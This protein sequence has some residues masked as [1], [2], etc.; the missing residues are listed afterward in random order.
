MGIEEITSRIVS[1]AETEAKSIGD[2]AK[3]KSGAVLAEARARAD[4]MTGDARA[5][6]EED[7][8]KMLSRRQS[9]AEIDG[10]K[11]I[12]DAKQKLIAECFNRTADRIT[13]MDSEKYVDFLFRTVKST[14]ETEGELILNRRDRASVGEALVKK[15]AEGIPGSKITLSEEER[16]IK[17]GFLLKKGSVYVN[18]TVEALI[19]EAKEKLTGEVA[20]RL[21]Q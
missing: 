4:K 3:E 16:D 2:E 21:F 11:L 13:S 6:G 19:D 8:A 9:V 12:L 20:V 17:G 7:K 5:R 14:G 1:D 15:I 18:G 10:R